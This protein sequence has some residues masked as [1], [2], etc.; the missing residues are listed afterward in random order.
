MAT[1]RKIEIWTPEPI[2]QQTV[3]LRLVPSLTD[4]DIVLQAV[5]AN[6][7]GVDGGKLLKI[8]AD[9]IL[10]IPNVNDDLGFETDVTGRVKVKS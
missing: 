9:A 3:F 6:G 5:D 8:T 2:V 7:E 4:G 1:I 10:T